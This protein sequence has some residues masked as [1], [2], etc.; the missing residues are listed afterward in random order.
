MLASITRRPL[1]YLEGTTL[2]RGHQ[3][4]PWTLWLATGGAHYPKSY[5]ILPSW[6]LHRHLQPLQA[7]TSLLSAPITTRPWVLSVL[8][9]IKSPWQPRSASSS[10]WRFHFQLAPIATNLLWH[11]HCFSVSSSPCDLLLPVFVM[12]YVI[13]CTD[14]NV[15]ISSSC[16]TRQQFSIYAVLWPFRYLIKQSCGKNKKVTRAREFSANWLLWI[17]YWWKIYL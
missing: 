14:K 3:Q 10:P 6:A 11:L 13:F 1:S 17:Y 16:T 8:R 12:H 5:K 4:F 9:Q 15:L 7:L 2:H